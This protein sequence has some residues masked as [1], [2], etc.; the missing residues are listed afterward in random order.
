MFIPVMRLLIK[1]PNMNPYIKK[2]LSLVNENNTIK[3]I[4]CA[5]FLVS[6]K[7]KK[8]VKLKSVNRII[9]NRNIENNLTNLIFIISKNFCLSGAT[10]KI[11][12]KQIIHIFTK[13]FAYVING[14]E[15]HTKKLK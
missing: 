6:E 11:R 5:I 12:S 14:I 3:R 15:R 10:T 2:R 8:N 9:N 7:S 13:A 4:I 1:T